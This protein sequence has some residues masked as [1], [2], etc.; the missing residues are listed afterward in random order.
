VPVAAV[1][2]DD[3][4]ETLGANSKRELAQLERLLQWRRAI[5]LM[6]PGVTWLDPMRI[7]IRG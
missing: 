6:E 2:A 3:N 4:W 1:V 7:D 5:A